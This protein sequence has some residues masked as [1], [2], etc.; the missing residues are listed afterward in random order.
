[1]C[2]SVVV[3]REGKKYQHQL[4]QSIFRSENIKKFNNSAGAPFSKAICQDL[5]TE[6]GLGYG[7]NRILSVRVVKNRSR[8]FFFIHDSVQYGC[9]FCEEDHVSCMYRIGFTSIRSFVLIPTT[10]WTQTVKRTARL[11]LILQAIQGDKSLL[12][13]ILA[14]A[15]FFLF[16]LDWYPYAL[17]H[18]YCTR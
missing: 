4:N 12:L 9:E 8:R 15:H 3:Y 11:I 1:M 5:W 17:S 6:S 14:Y 13:F 10:H 18:Y 2:R 7:S 16:S